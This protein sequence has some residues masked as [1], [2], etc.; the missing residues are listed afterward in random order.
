M[1]PRE[2][3]FCLAKHPPLQCFKLLL[4]TEACESGIAATYDTTMKLFVCLP[5]FYV[6]SLF[7]QSTTSAAEHMTAMPHAHSST[8]SSF[9]QICTRFFLLSTDL[10]NFSRLSHFLYCIHTRKKSFLPNASQ[11]LQICQRPTYAPISH[12]LPNGHIFETL[13]PHDFSLANF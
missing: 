8:F 9:F 5:S 4:C 11:T 3:I 6:P 1:R 13:Q 12:I 7:D 2:R 10:Y